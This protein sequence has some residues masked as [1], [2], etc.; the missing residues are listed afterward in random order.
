MDATALPDDHPVRGARKIKPGWPAAPTSDAALS[1]SVAS[2]VDE[3]AV[4]GAA[5]ALLDRH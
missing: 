4:T 2:Q 1:D 5:E 3:A